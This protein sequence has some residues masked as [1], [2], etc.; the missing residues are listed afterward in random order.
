MFDSGKSIR[1]MILN[2]IDEGNDPESIYMKY[3]FVTCLPV[4]KV[5]VRTR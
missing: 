3:E 4:K 5:K 2:T 1:S